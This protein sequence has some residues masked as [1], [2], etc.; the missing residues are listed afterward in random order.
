MKK[1][2]FVVSLFTVLVM[3][4]LQSET[5]YSISEPTSLNLP[6]PYNYIVYDKE[7]DTEV[8][9]YQTETTADEYVLYHFS[10]NDSLQFSERTMIASY[11]V[12]VYEPYEVPLIRMDNTNSFHFYVED[13]NHDVKYI[14]KIDNYRQGTSTL[15]VSTLQTE[16]NHYTSVCDSLL[17][18][19]KR[20][21]AEEWEDRYSEFYKFNLETMEL[22]LFKADCYY[23]EWYFRIG[24]EW[25]FQSHYTDMSYH[26]D[27]SLTFVDSLQIDETYFPNDLWV[28][29][30]YSSWSD[31]FGNGFLYAYDDGVLPMRYNHVT[32]FE[33][34]PGQLLIE[35]VGWYHP[36]SIKKV[37]NNRV[38]GA[39][40]SYDMGPLDVLGYTELNETG[41]HGFGPVS[42]DYEFRG[43]FSS[44]GHYIVF[45]NN[46][47]SNML[48]VY[49]KDLNAVYQVEPFNIENANYPMDT[50]F[51]MLIFRGNTPN[52]LIYSDFE[53]TMPNSDD[54]NPAVKSITTSNYPNPF[55]PTTTIEY[56][57]PEKG[58]VSIEIY[59]ILGQRVNALTNSEH[60]KGT[61]AI[62]WDGKDKN[63]K[64][65]PSGIYFYRVSQKG[66]S[67]N[68]KIVMMK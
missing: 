27:N 2:F 68:K 53:M 22:T 62:Q 57:V 6:Y 60:S 3:S 17:L 67:V 55:N 48:T 64:T 30:L 50:Y 61:H 63:N 23:Y 36:Q 26:Y 10:M 37:S 31:S 33:F 35:D 46:G 44:Q 14:T 47:A 56:S 54:V 28:D 58:N 4:Q 18:L 19:Q 45:G 66:K 7:L 11:P 59:N 51:N 5:Q 12:P 38:I 29:N 52:S 39:S 42:F 25:L 21:P 43:S 16:F 32:Y 13:A 65:L 20:Y 24:T 41:W 49:D 8:H 1:F 34:R 15:D 40:E 9:F